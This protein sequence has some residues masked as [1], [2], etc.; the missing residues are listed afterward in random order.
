MTLLERGENQNSHVRC[1]AG[2]HPG[3]LDPVQVRH[4]HVHQ[5]DIGRK[6][7]GTF[8]GL[9]PGGGLADDLDGRVDREQLDEAGTHEVVVGG[10]Q[11]PGHGP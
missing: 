5:N 3:R 11:D 8:D 2:E 6:S 7:A 10:D 1:L 9:A 4:A